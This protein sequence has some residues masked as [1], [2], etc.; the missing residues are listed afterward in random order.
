M[1]AGF[2]MKRYLLFRIMRAVPLVIFISMLIFTLLHLAPGGPIGIFS[3]GP[4]MTQEDVIRTKENLGLDKPLPLQYLR[5]FKSTFLKLDFGKSY[6]TGRPVSE[7]ILERLP[8]TLELMGTAFLIAIILSLLSGVISAL[9]RGRVLDQFFSVVSVA[10]MS[11]PV[12]W[13]GLMAILIFSIKLGVFPAGGRSTIGAPFSLKDHLIHLVLPASV[14]ALAYFS[15]WSQYIRTGLIEALSGNFIRTAR[16]KGLRKRGVIFKHAM[17]N[18]VLP[19]VAAVS[20]QVSTLF[21]GAVI[22]ETVFSWPGM[23]RLFYE[24]L[25]RHDY[26]RVLGIV[27]VASLSIIIFNIIG[28]FV[29]ILLDPRSRP[30]MIESDMGGGNP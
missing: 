15:T 20:M 1:K 14:L 30:G 2:Y 21:T 27:V 4:R 18:A 6:I 16:A 12:F 28:D 26:S 23:G 17:R 8:A 11:I 25:Q 9:N 10:G 7:M 3:K 22:T 5:W 24:G 29:C 19:A 13:F